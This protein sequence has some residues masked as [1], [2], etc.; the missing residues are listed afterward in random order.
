[1][2]SPLHS[3]H[4]AAGARII[5]FAD[6]DMPVQY[7]D[8]IIAEVNAVR[9]GCG[10]FDVSH[11]GPI[12]LYGE[13][14]T[15]FLDTVLSYPASKIPH[16]KARYLM[17]CNSE[18]GIIDDV[19]V[20]HM[21]PIGY[22]WDR[23]IVVANAANEWDVKEWFEEQIAKSMADTQVFD[24]GYDAMIAVQGPEAEANVSK[25]VGEEAARL[26]RF[27]AARLAIDDMP[28]TV[29]RTGYTGE[30]GFEVTCADIIAPTAWQRLLDMGA[31][32]CGLGARDVLRLEAGLLLHGSDMT[33]ANNPYEVGL[34]WTV[35]K[36][37]REGYIPGKALTAIRD[38]GTPRKLTGFTVEGRGIARNGHKVSADGNHIGTVTSGTYSPTLER[39][40]GLAMVDTPYA[41][42][43]TEITI[44]VRGRAVTANVVKPPFYR[45]S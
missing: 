32:P 9:T 28:A 15:A 20:Y 39:S 13:D 16:H 36:P 34:G 11:M 3:T 26:E 22:P 5:R 40:I 23:Y 1:M 43:G 17:I 45:R 7:P 44:D 6:W 18:G 14:T 35:Y 24:V 33:V 25:L 41:Q 42:P 31:T 2:R 27:G 37:E 12:M 10:I 8:G 19:I 4:I 38:A 29:T 30:D 21:P